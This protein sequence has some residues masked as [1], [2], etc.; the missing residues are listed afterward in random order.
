MKAGERV[1]AMARVFNVRE[2]FTGADDMLPERLF[3]PLQGGLQKGRKIEQE[4]FEE[5]LKTYYQMV[6]WD[7]N[8]GVPTRAKLEELDIGWVADL[9]G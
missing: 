1:N 6:G 2:G 3:E 5:A 9:L 7:A 4:D 8:T